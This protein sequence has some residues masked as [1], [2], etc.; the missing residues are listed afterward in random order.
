MKNE[1][2]KSVNPETTAIQTK[3]ISDAM[4]NLLKVTKGKT[5]MK[6]A[7][8]DD[9]TFDMFSK[10]LI[11]FVS[12]DVNF[13]GGM[14]AIGGIC[15]NILDLD[16]DMQREVIQKLCSTQGI[17]ITE[18]TG[19]E[20][21]AIALFGRFPDMFRQS[22]KDT[23]A[24]KRVSSYLM[25]HRRMLNAAPGTSVR[26]AMGQ[27]VNPLLPRSAKELFN[28]LYSAATAQEQD[29]LT[30]LAGRCRI[31][32]DKWIENATNDP[33]GAKKANARKKKASK[34]KTGSK[35]ALK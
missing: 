32:Y 21:L 34:K 28:R 13:E 24:N 12:I 31:E 16:E 15:Q 22:G 30:Q 29:V 7:L 33:E 25:A 9:N 27:G 10:T 6:R 1:T 19:R 35:R 14:Q 8:A 20:G 26:D 23:L 11:G 2:L 18:K 5:R 17:D 3:A 4:E